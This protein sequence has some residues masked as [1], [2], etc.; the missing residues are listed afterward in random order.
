MAFTILSTPG[1]IQT[2]TFDY[3]ETSAKQA[4]YYAGLERDTDNT[5]IELT[6]SLV[7]NHQ[8]FQ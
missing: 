4:M 6:P 8:Q 7:Q 1:A 3:N 5:I 2:L